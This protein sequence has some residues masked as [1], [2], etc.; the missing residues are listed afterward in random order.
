MLFEK[1]LNTGPENKAF[2]PEKP[3]LGKKNKNT[4]SKNKEKKKKE[5]N[6]EKKKE[7]KSEMKKP[8]NAPL[9]RMAEQG[10]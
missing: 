1:K 5:E 3:T 4:F 9:F 6:R 8:G 2:V 10:C 7:T